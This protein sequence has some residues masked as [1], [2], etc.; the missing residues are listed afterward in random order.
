M[1]LPLSDDFQHALAR[2]SILAG[3]N[4]GGFNFGGWRVISLP[5][6]VNNLC[7][8]ISFSHEDKIHEHVR[9]SLLLGRRT[10]GN[11]AC[12]FHSFLQVFERGFL[13]KISYFDWKEDRFKPGK[14]L[15]LI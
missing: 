8:G 11:F 4:F 9:E 3:C 2:A 13:Q 5:P 7:K 6:S 15:N 10:K 14:L 1:C 12:C